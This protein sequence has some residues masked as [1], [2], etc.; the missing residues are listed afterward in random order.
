MNFIKENRKSS[1]IHVLAEKNYACKECEDTVN[2]KGY[3]TKHQYWKSWY[4]NW[5]VQSGK[6][7]T[8]TAPLWNFLIIAF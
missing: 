3:L 8:P 4:P 6:C 1:N 7:P 2:Q 5:F